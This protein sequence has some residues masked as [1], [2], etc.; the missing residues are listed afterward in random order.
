MFKNIFPDKLNRLVYK[1]PETSKGGPK[2][3]AEKATASPEALKKEQAALGKAIDDYAKQ[4]ESDVN[5]DRSMLHKDKIKI[6]LSNPKSYA[7]INGGLR[8]VVQSLAQA[9]KALSEGYSRGNLDYVRVKV[10]AA[11]QFAKSLRGAGDPFGHSAEMASVPKAKPE[12]KPKQKESVEASKYAK[13]ASKAEELA[14]LDQSSPAGKRR[15]TQ[16]H[17]ELRDL[18]DGV[19]VGKNKYMMKKGNMTIVRAKGPGTPAFKITM[20]YKHELVQG[21]RP[22]SKHAKRTE[23]VYVGGSEKDFA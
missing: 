19:M 20:E 10:D 16:L 17:A 4:I 12:D 21:G 13:L 14:M 22:G 2:A 6:D 7:D 23:T 9:K 3:S 1:G 5:I 8:D 18:A 15:A 11:Q